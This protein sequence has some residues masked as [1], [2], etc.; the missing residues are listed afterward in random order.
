MA[1]REPLARAASILPARTSNH[2]AALDHAAA[3]RIEANGA[4]T[5]ASAE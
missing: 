3:R 4:V 1:V 2:S 5:P